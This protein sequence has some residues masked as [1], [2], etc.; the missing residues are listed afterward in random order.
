MPVLR[1]ATSRRLRRFSFA[2][3]R[4]ALPRTARSAFTEN[5]PYK[6]AALFLSLLLWFLVERQSP[7]AVEENFEVLLLFR[8]DSSLVRVSPLPQV[9]ARLQVSPQDLPRL[10]TDKPRILRSFETDVDDSVIVTIRPRDL[11]LPEGV[12][13]KI[14]AVA[15]GSFVV[16]F[17]SLMQKT[18]PIRDALRLTAGDG[19]A[20]AGA[21]R[22]EPDSVSI[23]GRRQVV[24]RITSAATEARQLTIS[25]ASPVKV[26]IVSPAPGINVVPDSVMVRVPIVRMQFP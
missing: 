21:P 26:N 4:A 14:I 3:I 13:A 10:E 20:I 17:D 6:A 16:H 15:P 11:V 2:A 5:L 23:V 12:R 8:M 18:V 19:I 24:A 22:F 25:S 9:V 1:E 7:R